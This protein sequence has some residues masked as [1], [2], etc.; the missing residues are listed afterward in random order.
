MNVLQNIEYGLRFKKT[1]KSFENQAAY[2]SGIISKLNIQNLVSRTPASLSGGEKQKAALARALAPHPE[3]I[4]L[5]EPLSAVDKASRLSFHKILKQ[6][7]KEEK[8]T[9]I[10]ITHDHSEAFCLGDRISFIHKGCILQTDTPENIFRKPKTIAMAKFLGI[11]NIFSGFLQKS[12]SNLFF[13]AGPFSFII[14]EHLHKHTES[15]TDSIKLMI[16]PE[17]IFIPHKNSKSHKN[18][19][20]F[21]LFLKE[22]YPLNSRLIKAVFTAEKTK[23]TDNS[24]IHVITTFEKFKKREYNKK[25]RIIIDDNAFHFV[26]E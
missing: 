21:D 9:F 10:H 17:K 7:N 16:E 1:G 19:N 12:G 20:C 2:C 5:D 22:S 18:L 15:L 6:L 14:P 26:K 25:V 4:I 8:I 13:I 3:A 11:E 24:S 23:I